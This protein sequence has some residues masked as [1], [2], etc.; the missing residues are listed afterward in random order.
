MA[1]KE[2]T[3]VDIKLN[4]WMGNR[5]KQLRESAQISQNELGRQM[6]VARMTVINVENGT[7]TITSRDLYNASHIIGIHVS[8]FFPERD[9]NGEFVSQ[10]EYQ[11]LLEA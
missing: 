3:E 11:A 6:K 7:Q 9:A 5:F 4:V 10:A 8:E 1:K 2:L